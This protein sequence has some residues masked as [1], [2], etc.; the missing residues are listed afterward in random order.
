MKNIFLL[1]FLISI[2]FS[3]NDNNSKSLANENDAQILEEH[4]IS[5][6]EEL[7]QDNIIEPNKVDTL[8]KSINAFTK[9]FPNNKNTPKHLEL[10]AKYLGALGKNVEAVKVFNIIYS[11]YK[12]YENRA[13][14]L[15]MMAF[16]TEN[17]IGDKEKAKDYYER[18]LAEF[19]HNAL[20]KDAQITLDNID[21]TP[22]EFLE[23]I[24]KKNFEKK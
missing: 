10:K 15:F 13:D 6:I 21:K 9:E 2:F 14:A 16:I 7:K 5:T 22:E 17:N 24:Q 23:M 20:A 1:L 18:F 11:D 19:P 4:I 3:C 12:N 8:I